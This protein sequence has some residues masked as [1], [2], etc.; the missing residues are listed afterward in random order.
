MGDQIVDRIKHL[1]LGH[2]G[3]DTA[4]F[5][6]HIVVHH[7]ARGLAGGNDVAVGRDRRPL[8]PSPTMNV[9]QAPVPGVNLI[10]S[11]GPDA[12]ITKFEK[13]NASWLAIQV[14]PSFQLYLNVKPSQTGCEGPAF[15]GSNGPGGQDH[16]LASD[17]ASAPERSMPASTA[18]PA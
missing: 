13:K 7:R 9:S 15:G 8:Q 10:M 1:A 17:P 12:L 2:V 5:G 3:Q 11:P 18:T 14:G 6:R 16:C 4:P